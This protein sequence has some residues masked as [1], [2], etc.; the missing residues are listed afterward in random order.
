MGAM[1]DFPL[2]PTGGVEG[3]TPPRQGVPASWPPAPPPLPRWGVGD[4]LAGRGGRHWEEG[5]AGDLPPPLSLTCTLAAQ[6]G[7]GRCY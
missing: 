6:R 3:V 1:A 2:Y 5:C 7:E 4:Q